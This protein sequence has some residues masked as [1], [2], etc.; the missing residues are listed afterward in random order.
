MTYC[1]PA[2]ALLDVVVAAC[3]WATFPHVK[4]WHTTV[5][6][7]S[8]HEQPEKPFGASAVSSVVRTTVG[9]Y[10]NSLFLAFRYGEDRCGLGQ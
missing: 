5:A 8:L 10:G 1:L 9:M 7:Q 2:L 4:Q 3:E 6:S